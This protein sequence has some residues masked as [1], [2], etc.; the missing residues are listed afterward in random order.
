MVYS[1]R[2]RYAGAID[3][4]AYREGELVALDWK[5]SK[6]LYP[7]YALQVAAYAKAIEE[8]TRQQVTE[9]RG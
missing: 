9:V 8:M 5:T 1:A 4:L 6:G 3:A 2:H 7:E